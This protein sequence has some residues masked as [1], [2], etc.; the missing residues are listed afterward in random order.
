MP[1]E[2]RRA[3]LVDDVRVGHVAD[4]T[5]CVGHEPNLSSLAGYL[6]TGRDRSFLELRKGGAV[7]LDFPGRIVAGGAILQ[8]H[9]APGM[10]R[11]LR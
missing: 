8:W 5:A 1:R 7:L 2:R 11:E 6:L 4:R 10:L 9:L 3:A